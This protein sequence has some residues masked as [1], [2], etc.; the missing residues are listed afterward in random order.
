MMSIFGGLSKTGLAQEI[1]A[2]IALRTGVKVAP[3]TIEAHFAAENSGQNNPAGL[4]SRGKLI[5]FP[6]QSAFASEY[7]NTVSNDIAGAQA[8]GLIAPGQTS[9]SQQEYALAL[10]QGGKHPYCQS[11]CGTFYTSA[12]SSHLLESAPT[13]PAASGNPSGSALSTDVPTSF[14]GHVGVPTSKGI[15]ANVAAAHTSS[16]SGTPWWVFPVV[17][18][19]LVAAA[20]V[21]FAQLVKPAAET[22]VKGA[23]I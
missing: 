4:M 20:V 12:T 21:V 3:S 23:L 9:I 10:Q 18:I 1:A 19:G 13:S 22:A 2:E 17:V 8:K 5:E 11:G 14:T 7:V 6:N 15:Q 16:G